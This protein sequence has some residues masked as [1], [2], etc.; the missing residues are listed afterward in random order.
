M[1]SRNRPAVEYTDKTSSVVQ[2]YINEVVSKLDDPVWFWQK[3]YQEKCREM[4]AASVKIQ[5][6]KQKLKEFQEV[7]G[8]EQLE[9]NDLSQDV[10]LLVKSLVRNLQSGID[11]NHSEYVYCFM[12]TLRQWVRVE[13]LSVENV[14]ELTRQLKQCHMHA[15]STCKDNGNWFRTTQSI[16]EQTID[17][18]YTYFCSV[19]RQ[20]AREDSDAKE[21]RAKKKK[22]VKD[23][24]FTLAYLGS[25]NIMVLYCMYYWLIF[26]FSNFGR[27]CGDALQFCH[28]QVSGVEQRPAGQD[29][30]R[31]W[32]A[33]STQP[34]SR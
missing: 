30:T 7:D 29:L 11:L 9:S 24:K 32:K 23:A 19:Y 34:A 17:L 27:Y 8:Q 16:V 31:R 5:A 28:F 1:V 4:D 20:L 6:L 15:I 12:E 26:F 2:D 21:G 14:L 13:D 3:R 25:D 33:A 22:I 10:D 18:Y